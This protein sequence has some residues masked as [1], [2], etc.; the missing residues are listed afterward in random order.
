MELLRSRTNGSEAAPEMRNWQED[1][2]LGWGSRVGARRRLVTDVQKL[3]DPEEMEARLGLLR[4]S[5]GL[6]LRAKGT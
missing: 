1:T 6:H 3:E 4:R 5:K 2:T